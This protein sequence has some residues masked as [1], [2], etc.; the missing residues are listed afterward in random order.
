MALRQRFLDGMAQQLGR[1]EGWRGRILAR[2]LNRGN[3]SFVAAA[4]E[5]T[6]L[7]PGDVG[8]DIGFGGGIGLELLMAAVGPSGT[9]HGVDVSDTMVAAARRRFAE[10]CSSGRL[11]V[12]QGSIL[13]LPLADSSVDGAVTVNTLYFVD[14]LPAAFAD[15][16]RILRPGGRVVVGIGDPDSMARMAVTAH[17]FRLRPVEEVAAAM[18]SAGLASPVVEQF[19]EGE[20]KGHLLSGT[21][22]G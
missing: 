19:D 8:A 15:I 6:G 4:V 22:A 1:P 20:R 9:V 18:A 11:V 3:R 14:D 5:A 12:H 21:R 2:G 17:G 7:Q 10:Q 16:A 13:A